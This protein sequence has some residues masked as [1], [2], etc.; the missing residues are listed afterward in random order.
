MKKYH[1]FIFYCNTI[2][3]IR[4][5]LKLRSKNQDIIVALSTSLE[6]SDSFFKNILI[7]LYVPY[8]GICSDYREFVKE[9]YEE[10]DDCDSFEID[11]QKLDIL[12]KKEVDVIGRVEKI[13]T[14]QEEINDILNLN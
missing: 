10:C 6:P 13:I 7:K 12:K 2:S 5:V 11:E 14:L 3:R 4:E 9:L 1:W 8:E